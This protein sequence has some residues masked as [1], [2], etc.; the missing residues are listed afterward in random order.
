[1]SDRGSVYIRRLDNRE[2]VHTIPV[3][4]LVSYRDYERFLRGLLRKT[5]QD[6]YF[7]DDSEITFE[8]SNATT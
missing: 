5:D 2:S 3:S 8:V 1:M 4:D 7:V 6:R